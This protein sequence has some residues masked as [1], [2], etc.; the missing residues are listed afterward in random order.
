MDRLLMSPFQNYTGKR[1]QTVWL[2]SQCIRYVGRKSMYQ[3][4]ATAATVAMEQ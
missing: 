1:P 2:G 3:I 4:Q